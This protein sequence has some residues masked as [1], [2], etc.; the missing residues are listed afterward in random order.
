M[1]PEV[2]HGLMDPLGS[3][4]VH[5]GILTSVGF[6]KGTTKILRDPRLSWHRS[7]PPGTPVSLV[8]AL[9]QTL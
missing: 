6:S 9:P 5:S 1:A 8:A 7:I 2:F 4:Q 3:A